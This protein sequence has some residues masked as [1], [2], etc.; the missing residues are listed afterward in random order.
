[1]SRALKEGVK[2]MHTGISTGR[3]WLR[4]AALLLVLAVAQS[5]GQ[6]PY[7]QP[8]PEPTPL[9][10]T[11]E[12]AGGLVGGLVGL[13]AGGLCVERLLHLIHPQNYQTYVWRPFVG[14]APFGAVGAAGGTFLTGAALRQGGRLLPTLGY[15]AGAVAAG[16]A[17]IG[18]GVLADPEGRDLAWDLGLAGGA[19]YAV[20]P[21]IA[22]WGYNQSRNSSFASRILPGS[23]ALGS[24]VDK[25]GAP[26]LSIDV[27]LLSMKL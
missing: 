21:M 1:M 10:Y 9:T 3:H 13:V 16:A 17:L 22:T 15:E 25:N 14:G 5:S 7:E 20:S 11:A 4:L 2:L 12:A 27:R 6:L 18:L 24:V 26:A 23:V 19:V 8:N